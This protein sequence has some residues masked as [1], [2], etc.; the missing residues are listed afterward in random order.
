MDYSVK[1]NNNF[2][3]I[4][5]SDWTF[6]ELNILDIILSRIKEKNSIDVFIPLWELKDLAKFKRSSMNEWKTKIEEV[7]NKL[8]SLRITD[9]KTRYSEVINFFESFTITEDDE[10]KV[11]VSKRC[12]HFVNNLTKNYTTYSCN[13]FLEIK[14][15]YLKILYKLLKQWRTVGYLELNTYKFKTLLGIPESYSSSKITQRILSPALEEFKGIFKDLTWKV[16]KGR[17]H[18]SP[19]EKYIFIWKRDEIEEFDENKYLNKN[20]TASEEISFTEEEIDELYPSIEEVEFFF[21]E[22]YKPTYKIIDRKLLFVY[23]NGGEYLKKNYAKSIISFDVNGDVFEI[24]KEDDKL[25]A[26]ESN[27]KVTLDKKTQN[28]IDILEGQLLIPAQF[29]K[30]KEFPFDRTSRK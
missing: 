10:L 12:L 30:N 29:T 8:L 22:K 28:K 14:S 23:P 17:G 21:P 27:Y 25:V 2:N 18:G 26:Y 7:G 11:R 1:Y 3:N 19:I 24:V 5:L 13:E 9:F 16:Q 15:T 4:I 6:I 20:I